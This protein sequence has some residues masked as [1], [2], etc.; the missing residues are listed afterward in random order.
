MTYE[1]YEKIID[2]LRF[3]CI[4]DI[5]NIHAKNYDEYLKIWDFL[6]AFCDC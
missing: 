4:N 3:Y 5:A 1:E 6:E 2:D